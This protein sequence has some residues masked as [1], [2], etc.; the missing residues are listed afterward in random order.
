MIGIYSVH[1][2]DSLI[3]L[4]MH[5]TPQNLKTKDR[6]TALCLFHCNPETR[7]TSTS[8]FTLKLIPQLEF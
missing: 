2:Y 6:N 3:L 7:I 1:I 4:C 8:L 5:Y